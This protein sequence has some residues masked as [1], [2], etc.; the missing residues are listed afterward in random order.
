L[1]Y[2]PAS[3]NPPK[4][5]YLK[6]IADAYK[7]QGFVAVERY[8]PLKKEGILLIQVAKRFLITIL[9]QNKEAGSMQLAAARLD[10]KKIEVISKTPLV[11]KSRGEGYHMERI[12]IYHKP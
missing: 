8:E 7:I 9:V 6:V 10:L 5:N 12:G 2:D 3:K 11:L 4:R 1:F